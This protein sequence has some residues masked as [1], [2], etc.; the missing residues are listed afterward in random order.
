MY[1]VAVWEIRAWNVAWQSL[2]VNHSTSLLLSGGLV[3]RCL[4][5]TALVYYVIVTGTCIDLLL[6]VSI[7]IP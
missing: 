5:K 4:T 7:F 6:P 2:A 3:N 1:Y